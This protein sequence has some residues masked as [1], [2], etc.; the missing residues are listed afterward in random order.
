M[1]LYIGVDFH[2]HQQT[3]AW[4]DVRTG[5]TRTGDLVHDLATSLRRSH[6]FSLL[7]QMNERI[8]H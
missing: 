7:T 6:L 5:E 1:T 2:P 4:C 8:A 3:V